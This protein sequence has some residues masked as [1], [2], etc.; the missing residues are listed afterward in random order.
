VRADLIKFL[1]KR[2]RTMGDL[3]RRYG[4]A[5]IVETMRE[6][7]NTTDKP[8]MYAPAWDEGQ[9][10]LYWIEPEK[11]TAPWRKRFEKFNANLERTEVV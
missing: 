1:S 3:I 8:V 10:F 5:P 2:P 4:W 9:I 6:I 7:S 11:R